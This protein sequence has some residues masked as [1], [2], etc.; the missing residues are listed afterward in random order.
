[1][2]EELIRELRETSTCFGELDSVNVMMLEAADAIEK[3]EKKNEQQISG[4]TGRV[5]C[6]RCP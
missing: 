3:L 4:G 6:C 2:Y 1:M 5:D